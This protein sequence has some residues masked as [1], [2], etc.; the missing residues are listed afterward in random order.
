MEFTELTSKGVPIFMVEHFHSKGLKTL[1][2]GQ[3][4]AVT[5]GLLE[6]KSLLISTPTGSGKTAIALL[7]IS[8]DLQESIGKAI[9]LVPLRALASEKYEE[10]TKVFSKTSFRVGISTGDKD[11]AD[12]NI[13][14]A[15]VA[16]MTV[17]RLDSELRHDA[18]WLKDVKTVI[19]DE[20]HLLNDASRGPTLEIIITILK[21]ILGNIRIIGLSATIGNP[22]ELAKWLDATLVQDSWRPVELKK[23]IYRDGTVTFFDPKEKKE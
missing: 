11:E 17:E 13:A 20:I 14:K 6:D 21:Q 16:I 12:T 18:T 23:G 19:I 9:Y 5:A 15:D 4:K 10:F 7:S 3:E 1:N 8:K 2:P 22:E